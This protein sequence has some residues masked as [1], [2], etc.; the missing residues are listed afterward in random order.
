MDGLNV[1]QKGKMIMTK[2]IKRNYDR[3]YVDASDKI[4][5][6][7]ESRAKVMFVEHDYRTSE[8]ARAAYRQAIDRVRGG[9]MVRV[10]VSK[11]ELFLIR[12]DI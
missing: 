9:S 4:R 7:I 5:V 3:G 8:S 6:F 10:I 1:I 12:K 2:K 11:G